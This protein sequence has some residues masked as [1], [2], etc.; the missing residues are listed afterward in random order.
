[1]QGSPIHGSSSSSPFS[2][3][4]LRSRWVPCERVS[5]VVAFRQVHNKGP[6]G[7]RATHI[8]HF[9]Q[10]SCL[11]KEGLALDQGL[12]LICRGTIMVCNRQMKHSR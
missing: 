4:A 11:G 3:V 12:D 9:K 2:R 7:S 8:L 6:N 10:A 5:R 1:M